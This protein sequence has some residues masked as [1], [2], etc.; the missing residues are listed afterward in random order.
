ME[1]VRS[2]KPNDG[3]LETISECN[4]ENVVLIFDEIS[5][6]FRICPGGSHLKFNINPDI[7]VFAK[8]IG[9]GFPISAIIE[10]IKL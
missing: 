9:N 1:P 7:A 2:V 3:F 4:K 5:S 10:P 6:G 8:A